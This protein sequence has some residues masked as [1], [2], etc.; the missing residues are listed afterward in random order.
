MS[1]KVEFDHIAPFYDETRPAPTEEEMGALAE[2]LEGC[3]SVVDAG[4]GTGRF[5]L[6]LI[7]RGIDVVGVDLSVGMMG[8][9]RAKGV[10]AL[11]RG[12]IRRL[13]IADE[14][15]DAG[16][17]AHVLQLLPDPG[18]ALREL[19]RVARRS[20]VVQL[21]DWSV[22][23]RCTERA[24]PAKPVSGA[25][26]GARASPSGA[27]RA[28]FAHARG[29]ERDRRALH[30]PGRHPTPLPGCDGGGATRSLA[31]ARLRGSAA[32]GS[33]ARR[34]R[35][36]ARGRASEGIG[37]HREGCDDPFRPLGSEGPEGDPLTGAGLLGSWGQ[38]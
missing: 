2:L 27:R 24:A 14:R 19:G 33:R 10:H 17:L 23:S 20:V 1:G 3:R 13:P 31:T 28:L 34:D 35:A 15:V 9:A 21:A 7:A 4:V 5:A 12:D 11:I 16:F 37:L 38:V 30:C 8:R 6:P 32:P 36:S 22:R 26:R 18:P 25:R 29:A